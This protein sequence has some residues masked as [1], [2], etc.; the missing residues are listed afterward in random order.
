[1]RLRDIIG[2]ILALVLAIGVAFFTRLF[3]SRGEKP[4]ITEMQRSELGKILVAGKELHRGDVI[5]AGDLKWQEW[6]N[7]ALN[8]SY[9]KEGVLRAEDLVGAVVRDVLNQGEP[10]I[11]ANL[12]KP[13]DKSILAA[14]VTPGMRAISI[15]VTAQSASSGLI[16]PGDYVDV[17]SSRVITPTGGGNQYGDSRTIVSNVKVLAIDVEMIDTH[18]KP[19]NAPR[20]A[21]LQVTPGQAERITSSVKEGTLSLSLHSLESSES[22]SK[23]TQDEK[24]VV[25]KQGVVTLMRGKEKTEVSIQSQ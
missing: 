3:L 19:K 15:D 18:E 1:M 14:I 13:G 25:G 11:E 21:T 8:P 6:P 10:V 7:E 4:K 16:A 24:E 23:T 22:S 5:H 12:I 2:L 9:I 20:V 17:I